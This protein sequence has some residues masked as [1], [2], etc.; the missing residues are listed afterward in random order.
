MLTFSSDSHKPTHSDLMETVHDLELRHTV[1]PNIENLTKRTED[2]IFV[3]M[4]ETLHCVYAV[5]WIVDFFLPS[6]NKGTEQITRQIATYFAKIAHGTMPEMSLEDS[7]KYI[8]IPQNDRSS[9]QSS[10]NK[11]SSNDQSKSSSLANI[12]MP[13]SNSTSEDYETDESITDPVLGFFEGNSDESS[14]SHKPKN[15]KSKKS[16]DK[17]IVDLQTIGRKI[18]LVA[19]TTK[20]NNNETSF[21]AV[22]I[23]VANLKFNHRK[24]TEQMISSVV[25]E[26]GVIPELRSQ[27]GDV[28]SG[29]NYCERKKL[30]EN[31]TKK[32]RDSKQSAGWINQEKGHAWIREIVDAT[33][34]CVIADLFNKSLIDMQDHDY[35]EYTSVGGTK[36]EFKKYFNKDFVN[37]LSNAMPD[38]TFFINIITTGHNYDTSKIGSIEHDFCDLT[39][40]FLRKVPGS[41]DG[42]YMLKDAKDN[43]KVTFYRDHKNN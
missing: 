28:M 31:M 43:S 27:Y 14:C 10:K 11:K 25:G 12:R 22:Q 7:M 41:P 24:Y 37:S 29:F 18:A 42:V 4:G 15:K 21:K 9:E 13:P 16:D 23:K 26:H 20:I 40:G 8:P 33:H 30:E 5:D 19:H 2:L 3:R 6:T 38:K 39:A 34:G 1:V 17:F 36:K 35:F 32:K